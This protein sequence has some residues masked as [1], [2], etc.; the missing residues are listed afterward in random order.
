MKERMERTEKRK[1]ESKEGR[2]LKKEMWQR[3]YMALKTL[4]IYTLALYRKKI[5]DYRDLNYLSWKERYG[6]TFRVNLD[7]WVIKD[8]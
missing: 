8:D 6:M 7:I 1:E 3:N 4:M 2:N 5:A